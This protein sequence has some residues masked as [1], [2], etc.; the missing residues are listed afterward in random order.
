[1]L[2]ITDQIFLSLCL[3]LDTKLTNVIQDGSNV[4][5]ESLEDYLIRVDADSRYLGMEINFLSPSGVYNI[6]NFATLIKSG[7]IINTKHGFIL[8]TSD[9]GLIEI[10]NG[11]GSGTTTIDGHIIRSETDVFTQRPN[12]VLKAPL[13]V[14][15][16][17]LNSSTDIGIIVDS[18]LNSTSTNPVQNA[19]IFASLNQV[20]TDISDINVAVEDLQEQVVIVDSTLSETS[21]NAVQNKVITETINKILGVIVEHPVYIQP[22]TSITNVTQ[23]IENGSNLSGSIA[24]GF[25]QNDAGLTSSYELFRNTVS[26]SNTQNT[27][28]NEVG[29]QSPVTY[30]GRICYN[31]GITKNNNLD[32]PDTTGKILAGCINSASR[33][34]TPTLKCFFGPNAAIPTISSEIRSLIGNVF[35]TT[36][37]FTL[38]T[39]IVQTN[40]IVAIPATKSITSV[41]DTTN[42]NANLT[43]SYIVINN[44]FQVADAGTS[45]HA[46]KLYAMTT[47]IPYSTTANHVITIA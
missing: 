31:E 29:I 19:A 15:D 18:E 2:A 43:S 17:P 11:G 16:N 45:Y 9:D 7:G 36:L 1:M 44:N 26:V 6:N 34:I 28:Y 32:I 13:S 23:T 14:V 27:A 24:I 47:D 10:V 5:V 25:I 46:Y 12:L 40:F 38:V 37:T 30:Y 22:T 39:G 42:L 21:V 4:V 8:K 33:T 35:S 3:P 20:N 41:I